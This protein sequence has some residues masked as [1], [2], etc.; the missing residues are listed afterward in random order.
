MVSF[1]TLHSRISVKFINSNNYSKLL[2]GYNLDKKCSSCP[3]GQKQSREYFVVFKEWRTKLKKF[4]SQVLDLKFYCR[5][6]A[7]LQNKTSKFREPKALTARGVLGHA[8]PPR[9]LLTVAMLDLIHSHVIRKSVSP[10]LQSFVLRRHVGVH[11]DGHHLKNISSFY[12]NQS[13]C[14]PALSSSTNQQAINWKQL[15]W[16]CL[17]HGLMLHI[18]LTSLHLSPSDRIVQEKALWLW[19]LYQFMRAFFFFFHFNH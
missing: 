17:S 10:N 3:A 14:C 18:G 7:R 13:I 1:H 2:L 5:A 8:P 6:I 4:Q 16:P 15:V 19:L 11:P 12:L 9:K